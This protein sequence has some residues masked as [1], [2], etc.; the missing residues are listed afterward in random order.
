LCSHLYSHSNSPEGAYTVKALINYDEKP[1]SVELREVDS[2]EPGPGQVLIKVEATGVCGSDI[3][4]WKGPVSWQMNRPL[5]MGHEYA[6]TIVEVGAGVTR[7]QTGDRVTGETAAEICG[8]CS[9]CRTGNYNLCP[10]RKGYGALYDGSMAEYMVV[11]EGIL[12][13]IPEELTFVEAALTEPSAVAFNAVYVKSRVVPGDFVVVI[14]P[15]TIGLM[16]L[17]MVKLSSPSKVVM[18]GLGKDEAR[19]K[20]SGT[21][22]ADQLIYSD[23]EDA[24]E[25]VKTYGDGQGADLVVDAVGIAATIDL[26]LKVVRPNGQITKIGWDPN[27]VGS[28]IDALV[29]KAATMQGSFSH[30]W[31][32]WQRVLSLAANKKLD[33]GPM[34]KTFPMSEWLEAFQSMDNLS[35]AKAVL[36]P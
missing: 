19:M 32:T 6:G 27:P 2:P 4:I 30:T 15:G 12:H 36:I 28:S 17:Q 10:E 3:H 22:G 29:A 31:T 18:I 8:R 34:I 20:I 5:T 7:W 33:R 11:R 14:G 13:R 9:Y 1:G 25:A 23:R 35:L 26:S 21:F 16:V 24:V